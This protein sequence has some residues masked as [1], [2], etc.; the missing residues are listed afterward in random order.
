VKRKLEI[1]CVTLHGT[2]ADLAEAERYIAK[3]PH[4][5]LIASP[6]LSVA[7]ELNSAFVEALKNGNYTE[8]D[9]REH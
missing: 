2:A 6:P 7:I 8:T 5:V 1:I 4:S 3:C 9:I